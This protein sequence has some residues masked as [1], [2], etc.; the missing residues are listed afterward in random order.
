[1]KDKTMKLKKNNFD[2]SLLCDANI[3]CT[4]CDGGRWTYGY[5]GKRCRSQGRRYFYHSCNN[6]EQHWFYEL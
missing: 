5:S 6:L 3:V 2:V 4:D 1:M